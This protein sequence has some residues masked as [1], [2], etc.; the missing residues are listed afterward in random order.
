MRALVVT[1]MYPTA[2]RPASGP[3]VRDQVEALRRRDDVE[4]EL[5]TFP[6]GAR[7]YPAAAREL[8][9][10]YRRRRF[11]VV[12][13]H[14]GL[15]AWPA[16]LAGLGPV[17]VTLHGN[18]LLHPRSRPVTRAALPFTALPA[19]VSR[20]F[21]ENLPG[22]GRT[23]RVAV[24]PCGVDLGRFRPIPRREAR[25]RLG[26]DPDAPC[27]LFPHEPSRPLKRFDRAREAAGDVRLLTLGGVPP[28]EV[29]Y[30]VN[31]VN[32]VVVPSQDE[33]MGLAVIEA[34]ACDVP[35]FG[36]PVGIHPVALAGIEGSLC[37]PWD[38]EVWRAALAPHLTAADP[39]VDGRGSAQRFSADRMAARVVQAWREL[40]EGGG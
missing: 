36:T 17:V 22:A 14:F 33:G 39:R 28:E 29:P 18:D 1:N 40:V 27:L 3:F 2:E 23:R 31:A 32:A 21:S 5:F 10:R 20:A 8:R 25:A 34:S 24:L 7:E 19:T 16:L 12:H 4:V 13:A 9:R 38:P 15:T 37:A 6:P 26:L 35:A 11:D 30:W